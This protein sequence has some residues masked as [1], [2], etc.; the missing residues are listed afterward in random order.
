M[1]ELDINPNK[2]KRWVYKAYTF[3]FSQFFLQNVEQFLKLFIV[4]FGFLIDVQCDIN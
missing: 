3:L 2:A 4:Y 1:L